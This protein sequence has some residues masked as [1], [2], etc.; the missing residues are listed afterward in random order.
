MDE[1]HI[2]EFMMM[3][4]IAT[5][6]AGG[7]LRINA[8]DQPGVEAGKIATYALMDREGYEEKRA[9]LDAAAAKT[10]RRTL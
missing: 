6:H 7:I 4:M 9:A 8:F 5:A 1:S 10:T 3:M 2:G